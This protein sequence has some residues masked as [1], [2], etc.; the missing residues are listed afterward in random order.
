M[1]SYMSSDDEPLSEAGRELHYLLLWFPTV[2]ETP[3]GGAGLASCCTMSVAVTRQAVPFHLTPGVGPQRTAATRA[4]IGQIPVWSMLLGVAECVQSQHSP[5][6]VHSGADHPNK[7][8][9]SNCA[10]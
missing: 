3:M 7:A 6:R 9:H 8:A 1:Y 2:T 10:P 5:E 4:L